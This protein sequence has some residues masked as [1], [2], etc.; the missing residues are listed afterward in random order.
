MVQLSMIPFL[1]TEG[2]LFHSTRILVEV[3][4]TNLKFGGGELGSEKNNHLYK[5]IIK[6]GCDQLYHS[7]TRIL[8]TE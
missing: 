2:T 7:E 1:S 5:R 6:L 8:C 4:S 3:V